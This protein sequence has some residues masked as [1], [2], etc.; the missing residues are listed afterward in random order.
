LTKVEPRGNA[1]PPRILND[2]DREVTTIQ[3]L[4]LCLAVFDK[5]RG[6]QIE[7]FQAFATMNLSQ[8]DRGNSRVPPEEDPETLY[9]SGS[10]IS[11]HRVGAKTAL[12]FAGPEFHVI[13][14]AAG[15]AGEEI[16]HFSMSE[17]SAQ[18]VSYKP[19]AVV[20]EIECK[21]SGCLSV[22]QLSI[23]CAD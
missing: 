1:N 17:A 7:D 14:R 15:C 8:Q 21:G 20:G 13:S 12:F 23:H 5:G 3:P 6:F 11:F 19:T 22:G 9:T 10:Q 18:K 16:T 2:F 4:Q